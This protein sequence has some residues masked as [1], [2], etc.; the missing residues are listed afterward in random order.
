MYCKFSLLVLAFVL[1]RITTGASTLAGH[2]IISSEWQVLFNNEEKLQANT[3]TAQPVNRKKEINW[4]DAVESLS[5]LW[6][7]MPVK[8]PAGA[9]RGAWIPR[10]FDGDTDG[11]V[12][13]AKPVLGSAAVFSSV[14]V[15]HIVDAQRLLEVQERRPLGRQLA[16][17]L[18]PG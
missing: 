14:R 13:G 4:S 6:C 11:V 17:H 10:T 8:W 3:L 16:A 9:V 12:D 7:F 1:Q 2:A 5:T 15:G 18:G